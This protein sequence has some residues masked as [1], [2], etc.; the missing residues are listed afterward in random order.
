MAIIKQAKN[1]KV[2][3]NK[4]Y[5]VRAGSI[6]EVADKINIEAYK[7]NLVLNSGKKI[8]M[9][10]KEGGVKFANYSPPELK[11]EESPYKLESRFALE[12]LF[13]FAEK[14][15]LAMFS[16]WMVDIFGEDIPP[17]AYE[18]LYKD[19]SD[20]KEEIN[21]E[22]TVALDLPGNFAA[23]YSG[24]E[25]PGYKNHIIISQGFI[26]NALKYK[27]DQCRLLIALV[28]EFGHHLDYLLRFKYS[29]QKGD[30]PGDEGAKYTSK[31]N[32]EYR[33]YLIDPFK[34]KEQHYATATIEG[35]EKKMIWDFSDLHQKLLQYVENRTEKDDHNYA[36]Y[37][38]FGAGEGDDLHGFGH[39]HVEYEALKDIYKPEIEGEKAHHFTKQIYFGNWLR[40][41][42]QFID[43]MVV[44]PMANAMDLLSE[45][46]KQSFKD[47]SLENIKE[48]I[49]INR[50]TYNDK[51]TFKV[52]VGIDYEINKTFPFVH[53]IAKW[54][55][56][57]LS[58]VKLSREAITSL[59]ELIGIKEFGKLK[60][61][62]EGGPPQNFMKYL[63]DFRSQY[64]HVTSDLLGVYKPNEHIDNPAALL[65]EKEENRDLN[66]K[67]D[68]TFV[69]DPV[70]SQWNN[71]T[72]FG[73]KNY[74]RGHEGEEPF[75]SAYDTFIEF[76][77]KSTPNTV[78]GR[79]NF[80]AAMHILEDYYAHSNFSELAVMKVWNPKVFPWDDLPESCKKDTLDSQKA[81]AGSNRHAAHSVIADRSRIRFNTLDNSD[82]YA[83]ALKEYLRNNPGKTPQEYYRLK[84][85]PSGNWGTYYSHAECAIV[86]TGS[87]GKLDTLASIAPKIT[88][89]YL[90]IKIEDPEKL[91]EGERTFND[92][93]I[94]EMLKD[95]SLAQ[96]SDSYQ[97]NTIYQGK[98]DTI[99]SRV[100]EDYLAF[101]DMLVA[102]RWYLGGHSFSEIPGLFGFLDYISAYLKVIQNVFYHY[103]ALAAINMIDDYQT[104]VEQQLDALENGTWRVNKLGPT[105]TQVAKDNGRQ[106]LHDLSILLATKAVEKMGRLFDKKDLKQIKE[107]ADKIFFVHPVLTDWMDPIVIDWCKQNKNQWKLRMAEE[108]SVV[109]Y[110]L[111]NG[112]QEIQELLLELRLIRDKNMTGEQQYNF[113]KAYQGIP[114]KWHNIRNRIEKIWKE[115]GMDTI[116][117]FP[118]LS[119]STGYEKLEEEKGYTTK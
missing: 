89:H 68:N 101:R 109:L 53:F 46:N 37:E 13:K 49:E 103:L 63:Q 33:R 92:A 11:I 113:D 38:F 10:G 34:E 95:I 59:V 5:T 64:A 32:R 114:G 91:K 39:Q 82:L 35:E 97:N 47:I 69:K 25:Q 73:T 6:T 52:P 15:S 17:E 98:E 84:G 62:T 54:A 42:S 57:E 14:D 96:V 28:E 111:H 116:Q 16:L 88:D 106:P 83:P 2:Q 72:Q 87:F 58:P 77:N 79:I 8:Q 107:L 74:I 50:L 4:G 29:N 51:R 90:S 24:N 99:Y 85:F 3:V 118:E 71:N 44:R 12:Q 22:I 55:Y 60:E 23:Y 30:A 70:L 108:A 110:G 76:I 40:D 31:M 20:K 102:E 80:G 104:A 67:L 78:E 115:K 75:P 56:P 105:H 21:P 93:L 36:G 26:D 112:Q 41:F 119:D 100:F 9:E 61:E 81:D 117:K 18:Q 43:P 86:Q 19:A 1:I 48:L 45:E 27:E 94:Y 65:P 7:D 66:H